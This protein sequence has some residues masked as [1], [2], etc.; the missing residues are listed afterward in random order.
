MTLN[1]RKC[2]GWTVCGIALISFAAGTLISARLAHVKQVRAD[3][4]RVFGLRIYHAVAA[5]N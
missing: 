4:N 3:S 5:D 2:K 1:C